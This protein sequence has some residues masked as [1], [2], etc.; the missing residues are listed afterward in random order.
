MKINHIE[1]NVRV[2]GRGKPFIWGHGLTSSM[3]GE[4]ALDIFKWS[5][6][7]GAFQLIRYDARGHG[8]TASS[9]SPEHY[10]WRSLADDMTAIADA[11][12]V[13]RFAAGGQSMGC[14]TAI[15]AALKAPHRVE[16]LILAT[17]PTAWEGRKKVTEFLKQMAE[18]D[19]HLGGKRLARIADR[20]LK[21]DV[22]N[23]LVGAP[24]EKVGNMT[25]GLRTMD[26]RTLPVLYAGA[27]ST[28]LPSKDALRAIDIPVLIL[29]WTG[30]PGHPVETAAE[31]SRLLPQASLIVAENW[32]DVEKWPRLMRAFLTDFNS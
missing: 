9:Y 15:Y 23:W 24:D 22:P 1:F 6:F 11:L 32:S 17:P 27:A 20:R 31:L 4:D 3:D 14:G 25:V 28:D 2:R 7:A 21:H 8:G 18:T 13:E 12:N 26:R 29:A 16:S 19:A 10:H 5:D 30:D